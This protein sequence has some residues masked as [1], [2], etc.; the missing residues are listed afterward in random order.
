MKRDLPSS[1]IISSVHHIASVLERYD[2]QHVVSILSNAERIR[3]PAPSFGGRN[4]LRLAF[5]DLG[6]TWGGRFVVPTRDHVGTL[7]DFAR[8]WS[9]KGSLCCQCLGGVSRSAAAGLIAVATVFGENRDL[10]SRVAR[11]RSYFKPNLT[12]M[13]HADALLG[14]D[15]RLVDLVRDLPPPDREDEWGPVAIPL[16]QPND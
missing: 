5:D 12:M 15:L 11:S 3:F 1:I 2:V 9:G 6:H 4:V 16:D 7:I 14:L 8:E 10:L 13:K